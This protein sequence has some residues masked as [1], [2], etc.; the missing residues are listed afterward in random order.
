MWIISI[1]VFCSR[2]VY[3]LRVH[4]DVFMKAAGKR[5]KD[6]PKSEIRDHS[7]HTRV[8]FGGRQHGVC[9]PR[10]GLRS[11]SLNKTFKVVLLGWG[12]VSERV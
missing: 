3:T 11:I 10:H 7:S 9:H 4:F 12:D 1:H 5:V 6:E 2:S 8:V